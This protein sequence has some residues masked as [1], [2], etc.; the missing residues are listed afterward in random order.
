[1]VVLPSQPPIRDFFQRQEINDLKE[2]RATLINFDQLFGKNR[3]PVGR[4]GVFQRGQ[5]HRMRAT[6]DRPL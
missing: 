1:M 5:Y 6:K 4:S 2:L 3:K